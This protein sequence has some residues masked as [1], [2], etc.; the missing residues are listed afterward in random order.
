MSNYFKGRGKLYQAVRNLSADV[1]E[2][3]FSAITNAMAFMGNVSDF[4]IEPSVTRDKVMNFWDGTD[5]TD[6]SLV[7]ES[8]WKIN[9][10]AEE[11]SF[12]NMRIALFGK[13]HR[14]AG[15]TV[16]GAFFSVKNTAT[17]KW[18]E[19]K[20]TAALPLNMGVKVA[21]ELT[22]GGLFIDNY[23]YFDPASVVVTDS[24]A[25]P[26]TLTKGTHYT[27]SAVSGNFFFKSF[28]AGVT[29]PLKVDFDVTLAIDT[30]S[31]PIAF[32]QPYVLTH[33]NLQTCV[34]KDSDSPAATVDPALYDLDGEAGMITF[35]SK[36]G[37]DA[38]D[39]VYPLKV[40]TTYGE[41]RQITLGEVKSYERWL[42]FVGTNMV[43]Q[44]R[45]IVDLYRVS[46]DPAKLALIA[47]A[48]TSIPFTGEA[49]NDPTK[50]ED[51]PMG[52]LGRII[53]V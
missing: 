32:G 50:P 30:F 27:V 52:R 5:S 19:Y 34:V 36:A 7:S 1:D 42:R 20:G 13:S 26:Q 3:G 35:N 29:F 40:Q 28:P 4:S 43:N 10:T 49:M 2:D 22:S 33:Q 47:K 46:F 9:I 51:G 18:S 39:L 24:S 16:T 37:L 38:L 11:A 14:F 48:T 41:A 23:T 44:Q 21:Q 45:C 53:L 15:E 6:L 25:T 31:D 8:T 17:K 12:G